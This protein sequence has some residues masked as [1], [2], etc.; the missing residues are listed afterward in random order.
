MPNGTRSPWKAGRQTTMNDRP[1]NFP[2]RGDVFDVGFDPT[3]GSEIGKKR[4]AIVVSNNIN[5]QYANTVTVVPITSSSSRRHY[6][7]EVALPAGAGGLDRD[8]R[9]KCDQIRT[10]GKR[11]IA[12]RRGVL[13][14]EY[15]LLLDRAIKVHLGIP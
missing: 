12:R 6:P 2:R 7:Y 3:L 5:N 13:S 9:A 4:P 10:V 11:R 14:M 1:T 15:L 8:S